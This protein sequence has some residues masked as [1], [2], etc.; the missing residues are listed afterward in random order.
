ML[1]AATTMPFLNPH[2]ELDWLGQGW[3]SG[4]AELRILYGRRRVGKSA[5]LDEFARGK[6]HIVYQAV[7]GTTTDQLRDLTD[8]ILA[9]QDDPVLR[10]APLPNWDAAL[11]YLAR[12]AR[13]AAE[14]PLLVL[15]DEYQYLAEADPTLASR[16]QRWWS[17]QASQVPI[18]LILC[19]SYIRFFVKNVLTGPAYGRTTGALQLKPLGYRDAALF[20]PDWSYEDRVRAY[21]IL[22]GV[23]HYLLQFD[24]SQSIPWNIQ[25]RILQR[26]AAL[27][28]DAELLVREELRE[29]RV[30]F[31][32]L[33]AIAGGSTRLSQIADQVQGTG[34]T[35]NLS[36]YVATLQELGLTEYRRPVV[37]ERMR[38]GIWTIADPYL[39]FWFRFV[40]PNQAQLEHGGSVE[41]VYQTNVAPALNHFVSKPAFED[42]CRVWVLDQANH[43]VWPTIDRVGAW[44]GPIPDPRPG[45]PRRQAEGEIDVVAAAGSR[46]ILAGEAKW[47]AEQVG[48]TVLNHL[49]EIVQH[50]PGADAST[51]LVLF[52]RAFDPRLVEAAERERVRL[53][54]PTDLYTG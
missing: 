33:R 26:G 9:C 36:S 23:P 27:Y 48:F 10:A 24:A 42:I 21:A 14:Q 15:F 13:L 46:V 1:R 25:Q 20:F 49:R 47:T 2:T 41:R 44:W 11:A 52:G 32:I 30:Y 39:R 7:E 12:L 34:S 37:G 6:R 4:R 53:V 28:Q 54:S 19:G 45:Q 8:A 5:L 18:Y 51:E 43:G 50:L 31:S 17:R 35:T 3:S 16:L 40:L 22:G 38:R 29:P